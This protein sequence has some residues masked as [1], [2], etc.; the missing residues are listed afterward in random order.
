METTSES[1]QDGGITSGEDNSF[2]RSGVESQG[3]PADRER[4]Y[5]EQQL[6]G[7]LSAQYG[8][9]G[10]GSSA[11]ES[12]MQSNY[13][14]FMMPPSYPTMMMQGGG[15]I[16]TTSTPSSAAANTA[17]FFSQ[18]SLVKDS[19]GNA[20]AGSPLNLQTVGQNDRVRVSGLEFSAATAAVLAQTQQQ[21]HPSAAASPSLQQQ[22]RGSPHLSAGSSYPQPA[23]QTQGAPG[24]NVPGYGAMS[25]GQM[26][27]GQGRF[28]G[29]GSKTDYPPPPKRPL[30]PY[31]RYN[32]QMWEKVKA[33]NPSMG[34]CEISATIG[35]MWR[36]LGP[37]EKQRHNDDYT[38]DKA[39]Y[40]EELKA[41][42]KATGLRSSDLVKAKPKK[43]PAA[44]PAAKRPA[45]APAPAA[46]APQQARQATASNDHHQQ[47]LQ[48]QQQQ[49]AAHHAQVAAN[50]HQQQQIQALMGLPMGAGSLPIGVGFQN[51]ANMAPMLSF[52]QMWANAAAGQQYTGG[53]V[54]AGQL[55][56]LYGGM[57]GIEA[58]PPAHTQQPSASGDGQASALYRYPQNFM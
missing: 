32:R 20:A 3:G 13:P 51:M 44:T 56:E 50:H 40:D 33:A 37:E 4:Q 24:A 48:Q 49:Q 22:P 27:A 8:G 29:E 55:Q 14:S 19:D 57:N 6:S 5:S 31:M 16:S 53:L 39:R 18:N 26:A 58:P 43:K 10:G 15:M 30:T 34:V 54:T 17:A 46:P 23:H 21:R 7:Q 41:Y 11:N 1:D 9:S 35:R 2:D 47:Q 45:A 42:L 25:G 36:E 38:L 12:Q 52:Q 28:P